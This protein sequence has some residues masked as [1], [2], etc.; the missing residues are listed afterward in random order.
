MNHIFFLA[1]ELINFAP[2]FQIKQLLKLVTLKFAN[3][4]SSLI[5]FSTLLVIYVL[6]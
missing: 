1:H 2:T 5:I 6:Q 3:F 4:F